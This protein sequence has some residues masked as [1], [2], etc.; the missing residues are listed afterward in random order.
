[1]AEIEETLKEL[2][3]KYPKLELPLTLLEMN[4]RYA[5]DN[6]NRCRYHKLMDNVMWIGKYIGEAT[7]E[8][9]SKD[10]LRLIEAKDVLY[11]KLAKLLVEKC[12][13]EA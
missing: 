11:G 10:I 2:K 5:E 9:E 3:R 12:G 13:C 8:M 7:P 1:M 6:A 4:V